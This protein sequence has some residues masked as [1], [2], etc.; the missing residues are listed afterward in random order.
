MD[1]PQLVK[2]ISDIDKFVVFTNVIPNDLV[3]ITLTMLFS[4]E[5]DV[6]LPMIERFSTSFMV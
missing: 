5:S 3:Q 2:V 1:A 6:L 4:S